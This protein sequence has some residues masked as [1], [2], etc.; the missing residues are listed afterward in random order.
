MEEHYGHLFDS[1]I[2]FN[3]VE[4][5]AVVL[6]HFRRDLDGLSVVVLLEQV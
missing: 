2:P 3:D 4:E 5:V 6:F 1:V